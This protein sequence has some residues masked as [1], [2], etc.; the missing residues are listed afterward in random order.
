MESLTDPCHKC[1]H[2]YGRV[3]NGTLLVCGM[4][5]TGPAVPGDCEDY[6]ALHLPSG[7]FR[8]T[9]TLPFQLPPWDIAEAADIIDAEP[10]TDDVVP[11]FDST[12]RRLIDRFTRGEENENG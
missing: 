11:R 8:T 1:R 2:L 5:A 9:S 12:F 10:S 6:E 7:K 4:H 3:H